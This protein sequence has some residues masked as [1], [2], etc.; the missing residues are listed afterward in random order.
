MVAVRMV[1][2][3]SVPMRKLFLV[4]TNV[5]NLINSN[6]KEDE[7]CSHNL[8]RLY[9][10]Y[11]GDIL[12]FEEDIVQVFGK[13]QLERMYQGRENKVQVSMIYYPEKNEFR[14]TVTLQAVMKYYKV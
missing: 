14:G 1:L 9:T 11:Y 5:R 8:N 3:R 13:E 10:M 2:Q 6:K 7:T 4:R 12:E